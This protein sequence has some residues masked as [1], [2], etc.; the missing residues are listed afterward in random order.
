MT[1]FKGMFTECLTFCVIKRVLEL[2]DFFWVDGE[3]ERL[4]EGVKQT[5]PHEHNETNRLN[6][7]LIWS[8]VK[9]FQKVSALTATTGDFKLSTV[10]TFN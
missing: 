6:M 4:E 1:D 10:D 7:N 3:I 9:R 8:I 2:V 5:M